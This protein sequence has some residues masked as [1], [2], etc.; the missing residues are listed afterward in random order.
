MR[1]AV[2]VPCYN[3]VASIGKVVRDFL[4]ADPTVT[5]YVYDNNSSDGTAD[6]ASAAGATVVREYRQGKGRVVR[7]MFR[8]IDADI[9]VMVDGDDTYPAEDALAMR[10]YIENRTADMVIGDRLSSTY[11]QQNKRRF[12]GAGN[13]LVR[14]LVNWLFAGD[15]QDIM[16]GCRCMSRP[17]VKTMPV[18][19]PGFEL[20]TELTV[21]ALDKSFLIKE[22]PIAYRDRGEQSVSKLNTFSDGLRVLLMLAKLFRDYRPMRFFG[23]VAFVLAVAA[24]AAFIVPLREYWATGMVL[25]MP[26]LIVSIGLGIGSM[27]A[28]TC[29]ALLDSIRTHS[30]QSYEL[31]LSR[32]LQTDPW[33]PRN[34]SR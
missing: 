23:A 1:T 3:E 14:F 34:A 2:L 21:H 31:E 28:F 25:R 9:Y 29:G 20:E 18:M 19:S 17:F 33:P 15:I 12:H 26:T 8:D 24:L 22:V 6:A 7:S 11:F 4:E 27:L 10:C 32:F 16:S 13:R 5:V 30:R